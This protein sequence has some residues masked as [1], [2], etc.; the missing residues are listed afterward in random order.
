MNP[1][2]QAYLA[3][4]RI[5]LISEPEA[6]RVRELH[7]HW[8]RWF[9]RAKEFQGSRIEAQFAEARERFLCDPT[10]EHEH[11]LMVLADS[12]LTA[13]RHAVMASAALALRGRI[14][15]QAAQILNPHSQRIAQALQA[16]L[17]RRMAVA[18]PV[19]SSIKRAPEVKEAI[20]WNDYGYRLSSLVMGA[21]DTKSPLSP[22]ELSAE[23]FAWEPQSAPQKSPVPQ[24]K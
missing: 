10:I 6:Q 8:E 5:P 22:Y 16:E 1:E 24:T 2:Y 15:A 11:A 9:E 17:D 23:L 20:H 12:T 13:R 19:M 3:K 14:S 7:A 4:L 21:L 18:T